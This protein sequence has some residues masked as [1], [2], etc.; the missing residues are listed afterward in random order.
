MEPRARVCPRYVSIYLFL[1]IYLCYFF[2]TIIINNIIYTI[3]YALCSYVI[4]IYRCLKRFAL[5][6]PRYNLHEIP[7]TSA[8]A[9]TIRIIAA[10]VPRVPAAMPDAAVVASPIP[11]T[12]GSYVQPAAVPSI[13]YA[14]KEF[15]AIWNSRGEKNPR[16]QI[17]RRIITQYILYTVDSA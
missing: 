4:Y 1:F 5:H 13:F 3:Y 12:T 6:Q 9:R 11:N 15:A 2:P 7:F 16:Y 10:T 14:V 17:E 8:R